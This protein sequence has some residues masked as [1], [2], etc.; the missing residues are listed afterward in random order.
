MEIITADLNDYLRIYLLPSLLA[1][2]PPRVPPPSSRARRERRYGFYYRARRF[3][4]TTIDATRPCRWLPPAV[5]T[6]RAKRKSI[7]SVFVGSF[8]SRG[9]HMATRSKRASKY[10]EHFQRQER[11]KLLTKELSSAKTTWRNLPGGFADLQDDLFSR[12]W[13]RGCNVTN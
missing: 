1:L 12:G 11:R 2:P 9:S 7:I 6:I 4:S 13:T 10:S 3:F 8:G 5:F